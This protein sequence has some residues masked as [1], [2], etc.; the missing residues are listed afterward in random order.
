MRFL[1]EFK[2]KNNFLQTEYRAAVL[3]FFKNA[4][5]SYENGIYFDDFY[6]VGITKNFC[7]AVNLP[8]AVFEGDRIVLGEPEIHLLLSSG[9]ARTALILYNSI[10]MQKG[11]AYPLAYENEMTLIS[12]R[13]E[14]QKVIN[15]P[16]ISAKLLMP[17][18]VR[19]HQR[20]KNRDAYFA[21]DRDGFQDA[22]REVI[23]HQ[24]LTSGFLS[25]SVLDGFSFSPINMKRTVVKF[26]GQKIETSL[27]IFQM[28]G[29]VQ[30]LNF[31]YENGAGSRR[32]S[33]FGCFEVLTQGKEE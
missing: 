14:N 21:F 24:I 26:Y 27:G 18:C 30:L 33:G 5:T 23:R 25:E 19:F 7:F 22:L 28:S 11:R 3:S 31:L 16:T 9:D 17:L 20:E 29:D 4:L 1:F 13:L 6:K 32:S 2:L 15:Q 12:A 10:Y 8:K